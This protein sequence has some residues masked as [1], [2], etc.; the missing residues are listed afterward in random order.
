MFVKV[1]AK[2]PDE[3][4]ETCE[5]FVEALR[6]QRTRPWPNA[7]DAVRADGFDLGSARAG[8]LRAGWSL[9]VGVVVALVLGYQGVRSLAG[10]P[11]AGQMELKRS[12]FR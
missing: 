6:D 7:G 12:Q 3:R 9:A 10:I 4:L 2:Y 11:V 8:Q 5:R 1:L